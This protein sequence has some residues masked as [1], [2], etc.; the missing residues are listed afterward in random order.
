MVGEAGK[1]HPGQRIHFI[2]M[3]DWVETMSINEALTGMN[4]KQQL[5]PTIL[6]NLEV[7]KCYIFVCNFTFFTNSFS[8]G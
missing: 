3:C 5:G 4:I 2:P 7:V 1:K 8:V 6:Y